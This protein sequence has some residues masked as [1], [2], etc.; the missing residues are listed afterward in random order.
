MTNRFQW[1]VANFFE[2]RKAEILD[3]DWFLVEN[4]R[5]Q[6]W[7]SLYPLKFKSADYLLRFLKELSET[8]NV[9]VSIPFLTS[10]EDG[11]ERSLSDIVDI[12]MS[13]IPEDRKDLQILVVD[14]NNPDRQSN[15]IFTMSR[16]AKVR[17]ETRTMST[18]AYC[19]QLK[20]LCKSY[21]RPISR[22]H[23]WADAVVVDTDNE[24]ERY[25]KR[26]STRSANFKSWIAIV[27][28]FAAVI[29]PFF[30]RP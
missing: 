19:E 2:K 13:H 9:K 4:E 10:T 28:S 29:V 22:F 24:R 7:Q 21:C 1:R 8:S 11:G 16:N 6:Y 18:G 25:D 17:S 5:E 14:A 26:Y 30:T 3:R 20:K 15:L 27:I 12:Y 23:P